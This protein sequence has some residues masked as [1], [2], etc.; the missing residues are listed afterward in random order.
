[1]TERLKV[2]ARYLMPGD[3]LATGEVVQRVSRGSRT[4]IGKVE[5]YLRKTFDNGKVRDRMSIWGA[6]TIVG[7]IRG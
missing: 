4:P 5:V 2:Q 3:Y 7:I 6:Y 1:V